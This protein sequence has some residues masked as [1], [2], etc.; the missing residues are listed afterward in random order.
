MKF[1][2]D[3]YTLFTNDLPELY[4]P[5]VAD[6]SAPWFVT[7]FDTTMVATTNPFILKVE[8]NEKAFLRY[9]NTDQAFSSMETAFETGEGSYIHTITIGGL[10]GD[11]KTLYVKSQ[12]VFGNTNTQS[13]EVTYLIDTMQASFAWTDP[14]Y[15]T[16]NWPRGLATLGNSPSVVTKISPVITAYFRKNVVLDSI[17]KAFRVGLKISGGAAVYVNNVEIGRINLPLDDLNYDI[18]ATSTAAITKYFFMASLQSAAVLKKGVNTVAIEYHGTTET[19]TP[20]FDANIAMNTNWQIITP[21][22]SEWEYFDNGFMPPNLT[23]HDIISDVPMSNVI[24]EY[25][26]YPNYPNPFNP[27]TVIQFDLPK[28]GNVSL[29]VFDI[30]GREIATLINEQ[31]QAGLHKVNFNASG[32]SSGVYFYRI[33]AGSFSQTRKMVIMK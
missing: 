14:I 15:P 12:D 24:T 31:K 7:K 17:P 23:L 5:P 32:L 13:L 19:P 25:K 28:T 29:K 30:L 22:G 27:T 26:L 1:Y 4:Q 33:A 16:G 8:T 21:Y 11:E 6:T 9:S 18:N 2:N 10:Q 3:P 20:S